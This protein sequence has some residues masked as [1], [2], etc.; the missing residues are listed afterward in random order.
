MVLR[1]PTHK[2]HDP[3]WPGWYHHIRYRADMTHDPSPLVT[4]VIPCFNQGSFLAECVDS[5]LGQAEPRW[6]AIIVNDAST[7]LGVTA[8]ACEAQVVRDPRLRV[9]HL[10]ENAGRCG[11]RNAGIALARGVGLVP[12]DAD[13]A[14]CPTFLSATI[15]HLLAR[16][17]L[18]IVYTHYQR[19]GGRTDILRAE[20]WDERRLYFQRYIWACSLFRTA[21]VQ[22]LGCYQEA[23]R[24]GNEDFDLILR[25]VESGLA[26]HFIATPLV[27][28][29]SHPQSWTSSGVGGLDRVTR[30]R[31]L[32]LSD[33]RAAF[34][35][36]GAVAAFVSDTLRREAD[37][38]L[39]TGQTGAALSR[40]L[41]AVYHYPLNRNA[42]AVVWAAVLR[43]L[44]GR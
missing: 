11:A 25:L 5:L 13:D 16:P 39:A 3:R 38:L 35:R 31:N 15:P 4:F 2:H 33:H 32:L 44:M 9:I 42:L 21:S 36:H 18:G 17:E 10:A 8:E 14:L 37:A 24:D 7:D 43:M 41:A 6:E 28:Y 20:P 29:R 22:A 27:L 40:A 23:Y 12:L 34:E 19:F 26:A 1:P 30:T